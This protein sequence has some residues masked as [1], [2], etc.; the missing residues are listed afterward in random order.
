MI[1]KFT[2][3]AIRNVINGK[4]LIGQTIRTANHRWKQHLYR[5]RLGTHHNS[6]IQNV[7][8]KHG[9]DVFEL[10]ILDETATTIEELNA[11]EIFYVA[12]YGDYNLRPGG[13][14]YAMTEETKKKIGAASKGRK[15]PPVSKVTRERLSKA[16]TGKKFTEEHKRKLSESQKGRPGKIPNEETRRKISEAGKGRKCSKETRKRISLARTGTKHSEE[17][18]RKMSEAHLRRD[19]LKRTSKSIT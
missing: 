3:Y 17:T 14:N 12:C 13:K 5:L 1:N 10:I 15:M 7:W 2:I 19:A 11:L 9:E 8:N 18:K 16:L 6:Y 4:Q